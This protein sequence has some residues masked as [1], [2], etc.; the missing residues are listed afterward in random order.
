MLYQLP[1]LPNL[2]GGWKSLPLTIGPHHLEFIIPGEPDRLLDDPSVLE[3]NRQ[4]DYMP[5]WSY[6]WPAAEPFARV[7]QSAPWPIGSELLDLGSGTG[8]TGV[9]SLVRGDRVVFSDY[10]EQSLLLCRHNAVRNQ[11]ADPETLRLDWRKPE[12]RSFRIITGCEV[13]YEVRNHAP[14]IDVL[15]AMLADDGLAWIAD[16]GRFQTPRFY[17]LAIER[18]YNVRILDEALREQ[19]GPLSNQFQVIELKRPRRA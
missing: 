16:P 10:D 1:P 9:A 13:T 19:A 6:V 3:A 2:D 15:D 4:D 11:L 14:L 5:Y 7:L 18:G 12:G 17:E 8:L